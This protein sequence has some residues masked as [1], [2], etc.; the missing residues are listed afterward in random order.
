VTAALTAGLALAGGECGPALAQPALEVALQP[1]HTIR[2]SWPRSAST[3]TLESAVEVGEAAV[4]RRL[5]LPETVTQLEVVV[6]V[7]PGTA[8]RFFRLRETGLTHLVSCRRTKGNP[9][10]R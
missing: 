1:D 8:T 2:V 10:F 6:T 5:D 7:T 3:Y 9:A 4:W